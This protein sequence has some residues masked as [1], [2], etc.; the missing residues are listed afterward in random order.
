MH[1]SDVVVD[2]TVKVSPHLSVVDGHSI[3]DSI[4]KALRSHHEVKR[5]HVHV[6]P[7]TGN[8]RALNS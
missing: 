5:A 3:A 6:E 8:G 7:L 2:V 4:E 1:G